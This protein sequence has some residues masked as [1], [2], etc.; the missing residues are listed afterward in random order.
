M[1]EPIVLAAVIAGSVTLAGA[2]LTFIHSLLR[3]R[4]ESNRHQRQIELE[5][6]R[7]KLEEVQLAGELYNQRE[8]RLFEARIRSYPALFEALMPLGSRDRP[9]LTPE[10]ALEIESVLKEM[11]YY[12]VSSCASADS[13]GRL[14]ELRNTLVQFAAQ[15]AGVEEVG[16]KWIQLLRTLHVDLGRSDHFYVDNLDPQ[17][18]RD[19]RVH[20]SLQS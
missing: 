9:T 20:K 18:V 13:L 8:I 12:T 10:K 7:A 11:S 4:T 16:D 6:R 2:V 19:S 5:E 15:E 3:E 17:I 14:S 1:N